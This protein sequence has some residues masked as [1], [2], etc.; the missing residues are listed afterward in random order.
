MGY[1]HLKDRK[2]YEDI[3]DHHT[4]EWARFG[5]THYEKFYAE[6]KE[7]IPKDDTI[8]RP[9]YGP[10][11]NAFYMQSVGLELLARYEKREQSIRDWMAEDEA[12]DEQITNA[13]LSEEPYCH[14]CHKQ[15]L[16][17][18]DKSLMHR[19]EDAKHDDPE[20][21]LFMLRCPHCDKNSAFWE[22]GTA[23]KP[24]PTLCPKCKAEM[25]QKTRKTKQAI[26]FTYTCPSCQHSYKDKMDFG[27]EEAEEPDP[28]Y[29]KDRI[30][31]TLADKEF[32]DK[33]YAV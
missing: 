29:D 12:K 32:R 8:E 14:H 24:K 6:L 22:D 1:I 31:F 25:T 2:W 18:T 10:M 4:V 11:L 21:V 16:R 3:Y 20:E 7:K 30:H 27:K 5:M 15:G 17:I 19:N 33:L 23:W 26:T 9:A 13:R 28:D